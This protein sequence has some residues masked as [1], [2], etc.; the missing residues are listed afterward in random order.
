MFAKQD[1]YEKVLSAW[2]P[3]KEKMYWVVVKITNDKC[4]AED[5]LQEALIA[6]ID[7]Y[8]SLKDEMK[9]E[10]WFVTIAI[11]KA[12][13]MLEAKR[14]FVN[15][16]NIED[17]ISGLGMED[18]DSIIEFNSAI[19]YKDMIEFILNHL[20]PESKKYLFFLRYIEDRSMEDII[21]IT[22]IKEGTL[23]SIF[24]RM[25]KELALLLTK[26]YDLHV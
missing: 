14:I 11:R 15:L 19:Q 23:K 26:E 18:G 25:R 13:E 5:V 17:D 8:Q 10:P 16:E 21:K 9:F 1:H 4:L 7:K 22:G 2:R 6:A 12:Y 3:I 24:H 20:K